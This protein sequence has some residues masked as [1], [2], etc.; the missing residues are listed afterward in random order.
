MECVEVSVWTDDLL[1]RTLIG[2]MDLAKRGGMMMMMSCSHPPLGQLQLR[3]SR[4]RVV[5]AFNAIFG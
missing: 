4:R 3:K 2:V 1:P 5:G